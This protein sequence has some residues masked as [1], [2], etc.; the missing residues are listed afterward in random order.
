MVIG[1][2]LKGEKKMSENKTQYVQNGDHKIKWEV[3]NGVHTIKIIKD[4]IVEG[5]LLVEQEEKLSTTYT[6]D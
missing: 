5:Q 3:V 6:E 2:D 1:Q 4:I